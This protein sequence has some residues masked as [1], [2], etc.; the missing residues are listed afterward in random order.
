MRFS[1]QPSTFFNIKH[2]VITEVFPTSAPTLPSKRTDSSRLLV[3]NRTLQAAPLCKLSR[4]CNL[5]NDL[6]PT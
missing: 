3:K 4:W 2:R 5:Y 6:A 1:P